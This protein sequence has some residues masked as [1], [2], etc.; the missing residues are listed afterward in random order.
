M[1]PIT[2]SK[3]PKIQQVRAL[4]NQ[5]KERQESGKFI[6]EGVR[7]TEEALASGWLPE[8]VL[9]SPSLSQRGT[10][11]AVELRQRNVPIEEIDERLLNQLSDTQTSQGILA[12]LAQRT[13]P[14]PDEWDLLL[15]L[16][17][18]R[19]PGNLG[20]ILR[21]AAAAGV[22]G[23]LL[24][25]GTVD[26]FAPKVVRSGMGAHFRLP[27]HT[28]SWEEIRQMAKS[29]SASILIADAARGESCWS[30]NLC[31]ALVLAVG[32]EAEGLQTAAYEAADGLIHIP[33]PGRS[34]SLNASVAA[35]I[36]LFEIVRQR[37]Q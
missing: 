32:S 3:N 10:E 5:H 4:I 31:Q 18:L 13:L 19:D 7:L 11:L 35:S 36:L 2:S 22:Q 20:T 16:D 28:V 34:E 9:V 27:I 8:M 23:V 30:A 33:M 21:S 14:I 24:T 17:G 29:H 26:P 1:D 12:V 37:S 6:I 15:V 25:A